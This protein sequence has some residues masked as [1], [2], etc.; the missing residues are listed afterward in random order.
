MTQ[1]I[2]KHVKELE[3]LCWK[4]ALKRGN[5]APAIINNA[6]IQPL[7][8]PKFTKSFCIS[9]NSEEVVEC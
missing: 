3:T 6:E 9:E 2:G 7:E 1:P 8:G 5:W 4:C